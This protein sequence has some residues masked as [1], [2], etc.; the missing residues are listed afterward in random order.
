MK[1]QAQITGMHCQ[2]CKT[3]IHRALEDGG[4]K[5]ILIDFINGTVLFETTLRDTHSVDAQMRSIFLGLPG[6]S[7]KNLAL[8][9]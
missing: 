5:D 7:Y 6:Y 2:G 1:Y 4:M 3:L 9:S 8:I